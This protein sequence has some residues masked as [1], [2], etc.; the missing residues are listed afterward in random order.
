[1]SI[2]GGAARQG[3]LSFRLG[4][5]P[6][7]MPW[8]SLLGIVLVGYL[9]KGW[10][11]LDVADQTQTYTLTLVF[12]L[13][14]YASILGHELAHAWVAGA[15]GYPVQGITLWVLGGFTSYE[16]R[17]S[18]ALR[19]GLIAVSGPISSVAIGLVCALAATA[20]YD[21]DPR[22]YVVAYALAWSNIALGIYNALPGLPLDGG[23]V[24]KSIV[25]GV[26]RNEHKGT[27]I[28]AWSGRV[29]AVIVF[30]GPLALALSDGRAPS[31]TNII[32]G[33]LISTFLW[34][35]ASA[36]LKHARLTSRVPGLSARALARSAFAVAHDLPLSEALR[37]RDEV[38]ATRLVTLTPDGRP[39]AVDLPHAVEAVPLERRPWVPVSSVCAA[40]DPAA[41]LQGTLTGEPLL[42]A[43]AA[44]PA[45]HYL[46]ID[47]GG[48][49][50]GILA[51]DDVESALAGRP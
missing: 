22:I 25:W 5:I 39:N 42:E 16:R 8:S 29:V 32:F 35:G 34:Q 50:V 33:L 49:W 7:H 37:R 2:F 10:F 23:A 24:L 48:A 41:V 46:V 17:S 6:V 26:T 19:E 12:A 38:G 30:V 14:F 11:T 1:M 21:G 20:T 51:A 18:S 3:G 28:A 13:L 44:H 45:A 9:W 31:A 4:G 43:M 47:V 15:A 27:V 36:Q 40:L